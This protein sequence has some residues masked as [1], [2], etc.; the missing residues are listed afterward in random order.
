MRAT[1]S[2]VGLLEHCLAWAR[3]EMKWEWSSSPAAERG[4]RFHRAIARYAVTRE[5]EHVED[6]IAQEYAHACDWIDSLEIIGKSYLEVEIAFAWDPVTDTAE[7]I[8][9]DRDYS[10]AFGRLGGTADLVLV[11]KVDGKRVAVMVWDW[12]TGSGENA[13][14]QLRTLGLMA[15]RAYGVEHATVAALEVRASGV[16]EVAREELDS[17]ALAGVAGELAE[18]IAAIATAEPQPGSHCGEMYCPAR[19]HCPVGQVAMAQV[20]DVIPAERL[21]RRPDFRITDQIRTAEEAIWSVDVLRLMSA[22]VD[23]KKDEIKKLVPVAGWR[24]D[25]GRVLKETTSKIEAFDKHK[26]LAL[27]KQLGATDEQIGSLYYT[28]EKSNG[29]RV[30]GGATK[31][32]ARKSRAA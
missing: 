7:S 6:D 29:L 12:K 26:A 31:P 18:M 5:R 30:S 8:G 1:A 13:G 19:L 16:A 27:I 32:R 11:V 24:T 22:W 9:T 21:V 23:A 10:K 3:P 28:F 20:V 14:P 25:D 4:T 15:A 2:K 17:F